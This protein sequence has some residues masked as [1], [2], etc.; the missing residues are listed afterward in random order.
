MPAALI[1]HVD[2]LA[3]YGRDGRRRPPTTVVYFRFGNIASVI[4]TYDHLSGE[5]E[6]MCDPTI[7]V[8]IV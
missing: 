6:I 5:S 1:P 4:G 7:P 2:A 3:T 8:E